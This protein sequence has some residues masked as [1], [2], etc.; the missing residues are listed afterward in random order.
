MIWSRRLLMSVYLHHF[1]SHYGFGVYLAFGLAMNQQKSQVIL[2]F[3]YFSLKDI[4]TCSTPLKINN[5][6]GLKCCWSIIF[7]WM[8]KLC[9]LAAFH[10]VGAWGRLGA[11]NKKSSPRKYEA[12]GLYYDTIHLLIYKMPWWSIPLCERFIVPLG[13]WWSSTR[14]RYFQ[15]K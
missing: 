9:W 1:L 8:T 13:I 4:T 2:F 6:S 7:V 14:E 3:D 10:S 15:R 12:K 11:D 5:F